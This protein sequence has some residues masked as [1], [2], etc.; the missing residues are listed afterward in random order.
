MTPG[1]AQPPGM[2]PDMI[3]GMTDMP[4]RPKTRITLS[5]M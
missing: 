3:S 5:I 1:T 4:C 2:P